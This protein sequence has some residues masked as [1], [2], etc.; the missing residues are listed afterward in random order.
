MR[1]SA[2]LLPATLAVALL[3]AAGCSN[4]D[5]D[6]EMPVVPDDTTA[7][8]TPN[9]NVVP[10]AT[11]VPSDGDIAGDQAGTASNPLTVGTAEGVDGPF[12]VDSAG[13]SLY[14]LEGDRDGSG[15]TDEC[16]DTWP[17]L[18]VEDAMPSDSPG[19]QA[20]MVGVVTRPDGTR[21]VSYNGHPLYRYGADTGAGSTAGHGVEDQWGHWYLLSPEG[22][23]VSRSAAG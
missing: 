12:L 13:T 18:L 1:K 16:L 15:C 22:E 5:R 17:P 3:A 2:M 10:S 7:A 6:A 21:Q 20:G 11:N 19:L 23:E 4:A 9:D 14:F 8:T